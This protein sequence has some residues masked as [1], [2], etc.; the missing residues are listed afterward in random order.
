MQQSAGGGKLTSPNLRSF[1]TWQKD[2]NIALWELHVQVHLFG[3]QQRGNISVCVQNLIHVHTGLLQ[4]GSHILR[5]NICLN[6]ST[7]KKKF[8]LVS[9]SISVNFYIL[10][11]LRVLFK[12]RQQVRVG[13]CELSFHL[14]KTHT[15]KCGEV[16]RRFVQFDA[17]FLASFRITC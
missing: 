14:H 15:D 5:S 12:E 6:I 9:V 10:S 4:S 7:D 8:Y 2:R 3:L 17:Y 11:I 16:K 13:L 1:A